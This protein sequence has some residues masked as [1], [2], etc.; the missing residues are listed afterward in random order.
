MGDLLATTARGGKQ[1]RVNKLGDAIIIGLHRFGARACLT[2]RTTCG[3]DDSL[4]LTPEDLAAYRAL[5]DRS[6]QRK[7]KM[8][9]DDCQRF[10]TSTRRR[11]IALQRQQGSD[12]ERTG[13]EEKR[14]RE[15]VGRWFYERLLHKVGEFGGTRAPQTSPPESA[16]ASR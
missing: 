9:D 10:A 12:G 3:Y 11:I 16:E 6:P 15:V 14:S 8:C 7:K 1:V 13:S 4:T 2:T 5:A